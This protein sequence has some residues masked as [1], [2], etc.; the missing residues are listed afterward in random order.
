M[1]FV[2]AVLVYLIMALVLG[3]GILDLM[4]GHYW[5]LIAGVLGYILMLARLGCIPPKSHH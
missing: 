4:H 5:V 1:K 3:W 2:G